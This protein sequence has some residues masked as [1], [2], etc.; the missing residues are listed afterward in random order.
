MKSTTN[1]EYIVLVELKRLRRFC[2]SLTCSK[3]DAEDLLQNTVERLLKAEFPEVEFHIPWMLR[4]CRNIWLDE[5]K[6]RRVRGEAPGI[7]KNEQE[8]S[9]SDE[10]EIMQKLEA[11]KV[12]DAMSKLPEI[13]RSALALVAVEELSY[14]EAADILRIPIGTVMSRVARARV[15]LKSMLNMSQSNYTVN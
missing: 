5:I 7:K 15:N 12:L 2:F 14:S 11:R 9:S 6:Y 4:V 8:G 13:Q 10:V 3:A 1:N